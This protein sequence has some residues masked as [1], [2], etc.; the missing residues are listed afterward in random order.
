[1]PKVSLEEVLGSLFNWV[2][3]IEQIKLLVFP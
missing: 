2:H 1:M 3:E